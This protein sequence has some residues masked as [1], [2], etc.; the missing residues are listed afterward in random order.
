MKCNNLV[1]EN[2]LNDENQNEKYN[3]V[4]YTNLLKTNVNFAKNKSISVHRWYPFV[5]GFSEHFIT[6]ILDEIKFEN[7]RCLEPFA[8]SGTTPLVLQGKGIPCCSFEVSPFMHLLTSVKLRTDYTTKGFDLATESIKKSIAESSLCIRS[9]IE[10]PILKSIIDRDKRDKWLFNK[11]VMYGILDIKYG[12]L[13]L[14]NKKYRELFK[15]A[16]ASI[17]L[18]ISN[19]Y[20]NGKCL[21]YK[22][23]WTDK[24][25]TREYVHEL[26]MNKLTTIFK[27][28][29]KSMQDYKRENKKQ[30]S[31]YKLCNKGDVRKKIDLVENNSINLV[32]TSPPYLNSR[33]YTDSYMIEL[34]VLDLVRSYPNVRELRENTIRSHV[35]IKWKQEEIL[36]ISSLI[37]AY[38]NILTFKAEFW[39]DSIPDMII[40]YFNDMNVLFG[41]FNMKMVSGGKVYFNVANSA[42]YGVHIPTDVIIA[43]IA[44]KNGFLINEIRIARHIPSSSQQKDKIGYLRESVVVMTKI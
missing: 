18:E 15:V 37:E 28:D 36:N 8:G 13:V 23:N 4:D 11:K 33:D 41:K 25:I 14:K 40:G 3:F 42:Y 2:L 7:I 9:M 1:I 43:E 6:G 26:F 30:F 12:I 16:L 38:N 20:R 5:E 39:N 10:P 27:E 32:I 19:V 21:S 34:W 22:K 31:N 35:Q 17:L 29:I 44:E 24:Q